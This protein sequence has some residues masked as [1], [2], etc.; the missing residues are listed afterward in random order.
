MLPELWAEAS[1]VERAAIR[2]LGPLVITD[3]FRFMVH[4]GV[5]TEVGLEAWPTWKLVNRSDARVQLRWES[6][7]PVLDAVIDAGILRRGA[8][9][10][11]WQR[12]CGVDADG[13]PHPPLPGIRAA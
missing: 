11:A 2:R 10:G 6:T 13:V 3:L 8:I 4:P 12:L 7:R 1:R 5:Y 9:P